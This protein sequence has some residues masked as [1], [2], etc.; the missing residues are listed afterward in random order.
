M[1]N[2]AV[3][4]RVS[5][6]TKYNC[7]THYLAERY[8]QTSRHSW[9]ISSKLR[10]QFFFYLIIKHYCFVLNLQHKKENNEIEISFNDI[11]IQPV[12]RRWSTLSI[13]HIYDGY[14]LLSDSNKLPMKKFVFQTS[15][16]I[17]YFVSVIITRRNIKLSTETNEIK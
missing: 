15:L 13:E 12:K 14:R 3:V 4:W 16:F 1:R 8:K 17:M 7:K 5:N 2:I 10:S 9:L 11:T 6:H